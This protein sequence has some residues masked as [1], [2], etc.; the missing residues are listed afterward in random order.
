MRLRLRVSHHSYFA[1]VRLGGHTAIVRGKWYWL[2]LL[3]HLQIL[4]SASKYVLFY[5]VPENS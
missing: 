3:A 4:V 5:V 2:E 1:A